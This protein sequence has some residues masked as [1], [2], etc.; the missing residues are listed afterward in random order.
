VDDETPGVYEMEEIPGVADT[1]EEIPGV[2]DT[3]ETPRVGDDTPETKN[4]SN[5]A[6]IEEKIQNACLVE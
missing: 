6:E 3:G 4:E 5:Y 1:E 2:D